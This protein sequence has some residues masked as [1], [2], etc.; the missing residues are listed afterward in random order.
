MTFQTRT[1]A[2][3]GGS[4]MQPGHDGLRVNNITIPAEPWVN[5]VTIVPEHPRPEPGKFAAITVKTPEVARPSAPSSKRV[6]AS[7]EEYAIRWAALCRKEGHMPGVPRD[8]Q[9]RRDCPA[10][11]A[12]LKAALVHLVQGEDNRAGLADAIGVTDGQTISDIVRELRSKD[13]LLTY[14]RGRFTMMALSYLGE[15]AAL[16]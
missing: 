10:F 2:K 8:A 9:A 5:D 16:A 3:R 13:Y 15:K 4:Y 11:D 7:E 14:R 12:Y 6:P 1:I